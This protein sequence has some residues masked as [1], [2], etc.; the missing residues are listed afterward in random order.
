MSAQ[1]PVPTEKG[2]L[3][4]LAVCDAF[5]PPDAVQ[6]SIEQQRD[7]YDAL[8]ARFD[9]PR[10]PEMIFADGMLQR[11]PIRRYRPRK[12]STRTILLYLH[13]GG[14]VVG[15]LE[16]HHAICAEI[17]D[18]A[19]AEL[20]SVDYRLAPEYRWPAQ[21]DDGF[22]VLKHLLSAN[23]KV[24]L[25]GDSA[26]GNL[27]AGLALRARDEG[28]SGVVGQV[29]IYPTL[30][31]NLDAGSYAEMAAAPGLTTA[32]VAY[33]REMLQAPAGNEIAEP[34]QASSLAG[35]PPAFI[36]VAHFDPL[37]DD[38]RHYA[39]RLAAEG[40]EVWFREEPQMVHAWL[41]ARNMS[42]GARDG[43]RA[44]CEAIR[45]FAAS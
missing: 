22:T 44:V 29:L 1:S 43:F 11:I 13:G 26:G 33:Y 24:V 3:Q 7:W 21:T 38:G 40:V 2:I 34:L 19:G 18:F 35:L 41:R 12:I 4:F 14:F 6:A 27:A 5:Y 10:P 28:L 32:D 25:I 42:E 45:R 16:S 20:V 9:R 17:A 36:T 31:G 39:A 15:S 37:R 8:C 23:S 30:S